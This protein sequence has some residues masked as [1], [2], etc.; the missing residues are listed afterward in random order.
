LNQENVL[1]S[2]LHG[3]KEKLDG[4]KINLFG[5]FQVRRGRE[6]IE[7]REWGGQ[8]TRTL[9]KL[10]LTR[11]GH[12]FSRDEIMEALWP[13]VSPKAAERDL[14]VTVSR[15]RKALE[16]NLSRGSDS[17]YVL[18][19]SPGYSFNSQA[20][21]EV[22]AWEFEKHQ[23]KAETAQEE[24]RLEE[25]TNEYRA[26]LELLRSEYLAEDLYEDWAMEVRREWQERRLTILSGLSECLALRGLYTEAIEMCNQASALDEYRESLYRQ[27]MLYHYCA[28]EQALA[29]RT[30][31]RYAKTLKEGLGVSPSPEMDRLKERIEARDVPGVD[32][33]RRY[34]RPRRPLRFPYSLG[35]THFVGRDKEYAL[36]VGRLKETLEGSGS[37]VAVEGEAGVG[38]TRLVEEFLGYARSRGVHVLSGRCYERELGPPLEPVTDA[39]EPYVESPLGHPREKFGYQ[40][41]AGAE[42]GAWAHGALVG[43]LIRL[44][45]DA[46]GLVLFVDDVQWADPATLEFLAYAAGHISRERILLVLT[47]R[48]EDVARLSG[49]L[50]ALAERRA[51]ATLSLSRL[52]LEETKEFVGRMASRGFRGLLPLA[53]FLYQESEGN[54]FYAVEYLRWLIEASAVEID[55]RQRIRALKQELIQENVLPSGVRSLLEA[56]T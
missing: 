45:K 53:D 31:R 26:A 18:R 11:P 51:I 13:G 49:W 24:G 14:R 44:S 7:P 28:G 43:E 41:K 47:Y 20:N 32:T 6:L 23:N 22:D 34:P 12:A 42:E 50:G 38:K 54:P 5:E 4:L 17:R 48:R 36:L 1:L 16:P 8:K 19:R 56:R 25:A 2:A 3:L 30:F 10:L 37:T 39:F 40:Q 35:R 21:C 29:L 27:L 55:A 9:L 33:L 15:L 46:E 52:S